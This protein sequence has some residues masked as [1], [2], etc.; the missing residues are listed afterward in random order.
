MKWISDSDWIYGFES[1]QFFNFFFGKSGRT[2]RLSLSLWKME[3]NNTQGVKCLG[4]KHQLV[5]RVQKK[6]KKK[7]KEN[8]YQR[9]HGRI[10]EHEPYERNLGERGEKK[11]KCFKD[12][13]DSCVITALMNIDSPPTLLWLTLGSWRFTFLPFVSLGLQR[14][15][16]FPAKVAHCQKCCALKL[17]HKKKMLWYLLVTS[18]RRHVFAF[19]LGVHL[20]AEAVFHTLMVWVSHVLLGS[21]WNA[22]HWDRAPSHGS[23]ECS[24]LVSPAVDWLLGENFCLVEH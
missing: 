13:A 7:K 16:R 19:L 11:K 18:D 17:R 24:F 4:E 3:F 9:Q 20:I 2:W 5:F 21:G 12:S 8:V 6:K 22:S 10:E 1:L 23:Q 14:S 15:Q